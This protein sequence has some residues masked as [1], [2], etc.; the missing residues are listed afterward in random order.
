MTSRSARL[1]LLKARIDRGEYEIDSRAV[2]E[3]LIRRVRA[4]Q[5]LSPNGARTRAPRAPRRPR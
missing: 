3:A 4:A 5:R 1:A 2:A